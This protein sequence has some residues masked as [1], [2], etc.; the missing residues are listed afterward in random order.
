MAG[1]TTVMRVAAI[2]QHLAQI[3]SFVPAEK[4]RSESVI[5]SLA[6]WCQ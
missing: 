3:G 1:K 6:A 4:L 2:I 5:P